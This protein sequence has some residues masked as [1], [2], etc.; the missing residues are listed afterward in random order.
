VIGD[1][2]YSNF[3]LPHFHATV[4]TYHTPSAPKGIGRAQHANNTSNLTSERRATTTHLLLNQPLLLIRQ[5]THR[6][7]V[8]YIQLA[9]RRV[10][11]VSL[12]ILP[13]LLSGRKIHI[14]H[15]RAGVH[16]IDGSTVS[17][18]ACPG[19]GH[20]FNGSLGT[21]IDRLPDE[22]ERGG[23]ARDIHDATAAVGRKEGVAGL[24]EEERGENI[25]C[26]LP[27][28]VFGLDG[29]FG[30][31]VQVAVLRDTGVV[32][33]NVNLELVLGAEMLF[34]GGDDCFHGLGGLAEVGLHAL[35]FDVVGCC[36]GG[37]QCFGGSARRLGG[38]VQQ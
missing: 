9:Q 27:V 23:Y 30:G 14:T 4:G 10:I 2:D 25:N 18:L 12:N 35:A 21:A 11:L 5:A 38:K 16:G 31:V 36:Q 22:S 24:C 28:E 32:D 8:V 15:D 20:R 34:C 26:V 7:L 37:A 17:E 13:E 33:E 6:V 1:T 29:T 3:L 19:A